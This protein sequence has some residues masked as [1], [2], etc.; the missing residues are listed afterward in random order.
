MAALAAAE[1]VAHIG[2]HRREG[3]GSSGTQR[4]PLLRL[5]HGA[6]AARPESG[7]GQAGGLQNASEALFGGTVWQQTLIGASFWWRMTFK[8]MESMRKQLGPRPQI[9]P[10]SPSGT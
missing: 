4:V 3:A 6:V 2:A 5:G 9:R 10:A 8:R 7:F 1:P